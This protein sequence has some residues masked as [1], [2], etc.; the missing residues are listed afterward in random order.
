MMINF[1]HFEVHTL[2]QGPSCPLRTSD[3]AE[4][5]QFA[6][7]LSIQTVLEL[8][9]PAHTMSWGKS[10]PEI[11]T[12]CWDWMQT[13][14]KGEDRWDTQAIDP[15]N[16]EAKIG[17]V[18]PGGAAAGAPRPRPPLAGGAPPRA[19]GRPGGGPAQLPRGRTGV[20]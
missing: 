14:Q 8:D 3:M 7:D 6:D 9:T 2:R 16:Q 15:T 11:M 12:D 4:V 19:G 10:H 5:V 13:V 1:L 17:R 18:L 20:P